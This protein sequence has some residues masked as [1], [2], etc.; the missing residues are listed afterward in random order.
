MYTVNFLDFHAV[1]ILDF[2]A[3]LD[4]LDMDTEFSGN[5]MG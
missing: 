3:I 5:R 1:D 4:F 2:L